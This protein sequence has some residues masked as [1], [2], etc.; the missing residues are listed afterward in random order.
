M[1]LPRLFTPAE[2]AEALQQSENYVITQCRAGRWPCRRG[3]RNSIRLSAEDVTRIVEL[4]AQP[5][6][7]MQSLSFLTPRSQARRRRAS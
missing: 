1:T 6:D 3:A 2:V 5:A 7:E 4:L